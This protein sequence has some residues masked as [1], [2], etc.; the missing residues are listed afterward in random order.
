MDL[1]VLRY[2]QATLYMVYLSLKLRVR[3][4]CFAEMSDFTRKWCCPVSVWLFRFIVLTHLALSRHASHNQF[5]SYQKFNLINREYLIL[6]RCIIN[7]ILNGETEVTA[8]PIEM[9][10]IFIHG[11]QKLN[12][13]LVFWPPPEILYN[14]TRFSPVSSLEQKFKVLHG[15]LQIR[16]SERAT[17][18]CVKVL[19]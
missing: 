17:S 6:I 16:A 7:I 2:F 8:W 13:T 15:N 4:W 3:G 10:T 18:N 12:L 5:S 14:R 11:T 1:C 19:L 9:R